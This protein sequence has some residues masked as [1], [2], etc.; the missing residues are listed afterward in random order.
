L[1]IFSDVLITKTKTTKMLTLEI[2]NK[3][4]KDYLKAE[5]EAEC[6]GCNIGDDWRDVFLQETCNTYHTWF[7]FPFPVKDFS[8]ILICEMLTKIKQYDEDQGYETQGDLNISTI[9]EKY[10]YV[11]AEEYIHST[12]FYDLPPGQK[13]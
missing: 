4:I 6:E 8:G 7:R 12:D 3:A 5:Y 10:L 2:I 1:K 9:F 13:I 11:Y